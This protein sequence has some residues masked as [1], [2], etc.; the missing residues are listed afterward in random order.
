M[1]DGNR[2]LD[3]QPEP[4]TPNGHPCI[5]ATIFGH[6][7]IAETGS[8]LRSDKDAGRLIYAY[9]FPI[10]YPFLCTH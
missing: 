9:D 6:P 7:W 5:G 2:P 4:A 1:T 10:M 3:P 8:E